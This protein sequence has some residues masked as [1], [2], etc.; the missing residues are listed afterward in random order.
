MSNSYQTRWNAAFMANYGTPP[1]AID[2]GRG[3]TLWDTD[4]TEYLDLYAGIAVS[5]LG[6]A[7]PAIVEA[8]SRQI[9]QVAHTSNLM[10]N[11]RALELGER[12]TALVGHDAKVF[13]CNSGAEANEAAIKLV[14]RA[15]PDRSQIVAAEGGFHGRTTG[16]LSITGQPAKR[17]PFAPLLPDVT[18]VPYGDVEALRAAVTDQTAA[19][20]LEPVQGEAGVIPAPPGYLAAAREACDAAGALLVFDEVQGGVGRAG[21]WFSHWL[22]EPGVAPDVITMAKGLGGGLPIGACIGLGEAGLAL[23]PGDHA[24]TFGGNAVA[25]AAALATLD[26]IEADGLLAAST[27]R[28]EQLRTA[29]QHE[30]IEQVRGIGLWRGVVLREPVAKEVEA[31]AR[32]HGVLVNAVSPTVLR[33]APALVIGEAEIETGAAVVL[34]AL[35]EVTT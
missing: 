26:T 9:G 8:V 20:F 6:Q 15:C 29:L 18:F 3:V 1:L 2:R 35:A 24:T 10:I 31:T 19:V 12:L 27:E 11:V 30:L 25:C 14:R 32:Q 33:I 17:A 4:G 5:A 34:K 28:G 7:H 13:L 22:V 16:A 21:A 23:Q